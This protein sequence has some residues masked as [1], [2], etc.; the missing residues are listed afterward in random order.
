LGRGHG[1]TERVPQQGGGPDRLCGG[2]RPQPQLRSPGAQDLQ[3]LAGLLLARV[4]EHGRPTSATLASAL[5]APAAK[6]CSASP[7]L[8]AGLGWSV[9]VC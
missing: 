8:R 7:T 1:I 4:G 3:H 2:L 9:C 6:A 5:C